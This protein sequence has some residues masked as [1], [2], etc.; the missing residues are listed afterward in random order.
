MSSVARLRTSAVVRT[1]TT[2]EKQGFMKALGGGT[3]DHIVGFTMI[4]AGEV[5]TVVQTAMLA[6][7]PYSRFRDTI[8]AHPTM[9][10]GLGPAFLE[11]AA[12]VRPTRHAETGAV[13]GL[14]TGFNSDRWA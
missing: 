9:A 14:M 6:D 4:G 13:G 2:D 3:V 5:M 11:R 8:L 10:D 1:Q 12:S 7:V